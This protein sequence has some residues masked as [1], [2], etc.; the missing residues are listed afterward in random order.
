MR[1]ITS[2]ALIYISGEVFVKLFPFLLLP[3]LSR[4]LGPAGYAEL[5]LFN[6]YTSLFFIIIGLNTSTALLKFYFSETEKEIHYYFNAALLVILVATIAF[7]II[8]LITSNNIITL[9]VLI[10]SLQCVLTNL[11]TLKQAQKERWKYLIIQITYAV[12]SFL[13]TLVFLYYFPVSY[14]L[15]VYA[16][17]FAY[18]LSIGIA[19]YFSRKS[20]RFDF[21]QKFYEA[22]KQIVLF[23][24]PLLIHNFS[25]FARSGLDRIIIERYFP[26]NILGDYSVSF[27]L[28]MVITI[29]LMAFNKAVTPYMYEKLKKNTLRLSDYNRIFIYY[30]LIC[31]IV[32]FLCSQIPEK[33]YS[34]IVGD[35][36]DHIKELMTIFVPAFISQGFYMIMSSTCFYHNKNKKVAYCTLIGGIVHTVLLVLIGMHLT[37]I[38]VP[39]AL[40]TSNI[41]ISALIYIFVFRKI[42]FGNER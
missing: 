16:V 1:K 11:L 30:F 12:I 8:S 4:A 14:T 13:L 10:S 9:S 23:G 5:S 17:G 6:T 22:L 35:N 2:D 41:L 21:G 39:A 42:N 19:I 37:I 7:L 40:L 26:I 20:F 24:S 32:S 34:F 27:Q 36:Y 18:I 15:R 31:I 3:V 38:H 28:A 25:F 33:V 29:I